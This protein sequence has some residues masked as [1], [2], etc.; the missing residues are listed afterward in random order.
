[1]SMTILE[2]LAGKEPRGA[3]YRNKNAS[4]NVIYRLVRKHMAEIEEAIARGYSWKQIDTACRESWQVESDKASGIVWWKSGDLIEK[5]YRA[6]KTGRTAGRK[7]H[8]A[9]AKIA[10]DMRIT[11]R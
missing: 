5:C 4:L 8:T 2:S 1:M 3:R 7:A 10:L 11:P 6:V 9:A